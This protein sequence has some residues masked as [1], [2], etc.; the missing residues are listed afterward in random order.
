MDWRPE[1]IAPL[2]AALAAGSVIGYEREFRA[3]AAGFRTHALV[4]VGSA[5]LMIGAQHQIEWAGV[6][7]TDEVMRIDPVRMAHGIL[8]GIGFLCGGVIFKEGLSVHGLTTAA[9]LWTTSALG[10]LYGVG[11]YDLAIAGTVVTLVVLIAFRLVDRIAP[12]LALSD[13][14]VRY[15]R[16]EAPSE[17]ALCEEMAAL[18]LKPKRVAHRTTEDGAFVIYEITLTSRGRLGADDL[19]KHL[20]RDG[21]LVAYDIEPRNL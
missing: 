13:V 8:T 20:S 19:V 18:R 14:S 15:R 4:A 7:M 5:L 17:A 10:M 16:D 2:L 1:F 21:R 3:R 12:S 11:M 9:S 6:A